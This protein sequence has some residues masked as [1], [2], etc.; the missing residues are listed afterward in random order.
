MYTHYDQARQFAYN[1][2][3]ALYITCIQMI[4]GIGEAVKMNKNKLL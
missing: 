4:M 3:F 2:N 1:C